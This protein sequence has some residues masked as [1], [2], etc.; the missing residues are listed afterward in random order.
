MAEIIKIENRRNKP[1][2]RRNKPAR[3]KNNAFTILDIDRNIDENLKK[4][5]EADKL[6]G[7]KSPGELDP[8][9][10][11]Y[12]RFMQ[13]YNYEKETLKKLEKD[14]S[15]LVGDE[16]SKRLESK[17]KAYT[18]ELCDIL[19]FDE[20][21][22]EDKRKQYRLHGM[23]NDIIGEIKERYIPR[24]GRI[25]YGKKTP[26]E[27]L[28]LSE[29]EMNTIQFDG[30]KNRKIR[31]KYIQLE[32]KRDTY[33]IEDLLD[34]AWAYTCIK[35]EESREK[36][37]EEW[38]QQD[39]TSGEMR[40]I[41]DPYSILGMNKEKVL[42]REDTNTYIVNQY[43]IL[44]E[45]MGMGIAKSL[46]HKV[47]RTWAYDRIKDEPSRK[48]YNL[49][50]KKKMFA[51]MYSHK[52][53]SFSK[54]LKF[55]ISSVTNA[56]YTEEESHEIYELAKEDGQTLTFQKVGKIEYINA[57]NV[58]GRK[59]S[60]KIVTKD[61]DG[62]VVPVMIQDKEGKKVEVE[63]IVYIDLPILRMSDDSSPILT[64]F[65]C[66][67]VLDQ[68]A[69]T[70]CN[71]INGRDMGRIEG[72]EQEGYTICFDENEIKAAKIV[73]ARKAKLKD[74]IVNETKLKKTTGER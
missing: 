17:M 56:K 30:A 34:V 10:K 70:Q 67:Y 3:G 74:N 55:G 32:A 2:N 27:V 13:K 50:R 63:P 54:S 64:Q 7:K 31:E 58:I 41:K 19:A 61:R 9:K 37:E 23:D 69:V 36:W 18:S 35:D 68:M 43:E 51:Q 38:K 33:T 42:A 52:R 24:E 65:V 45:N 46:V 22:T 71:Q 20:I 40:E 60:Y 15:R 44:S 57:T 72:N 11:I 59:D 6:K 47:G 25:T 14:I 39:D 29:E 49:D 16:L 28:E 66:D 62:N 4:I 5:R 21:N 8:D 12:V 48:A 1:A 53:R 73:Q 26:Y